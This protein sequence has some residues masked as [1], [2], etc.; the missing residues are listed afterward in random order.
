MGM[1]ETAVATLE[2]MVAIVANLVTR[3][4]TMTTKPQEKI[5]GDISM[6][7]MLNRS[8]QKVLLLRPRLKSYRIS[9]R[10]GSL[11]IQELSCPRIRINLNRKSG[12]VE[13]IKLVPKYLS[14][15]LF[16]VELQLVINEADED[17]QFQIS[18]ASPD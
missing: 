2:T 15:P 16:L 11:I 4:Y 14:T 9:F 18:T 3:S 8:L 5:R 7:V 6:V 10:S 12:R 17:P 1:A 13:I